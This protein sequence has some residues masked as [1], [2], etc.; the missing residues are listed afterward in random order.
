[1]A[2]GRGA[3]EQRRSCSP[4]PVLLCSLVTSY[5]LLLLTKGGMVLRFS[6]PMIHIARKNEAKVGEAV[7]VPD[8]L[9]VDLLFARQCDTVA[10][11]PPGDR[12]RQMQKRSGDGAPGKH[13]L[14]KGWQL[15]LACVDVS[16]EGLD[17]LDCH[18]W[19]SPGALVCSLRQGQVCAKNEQVILYPSHNPVH[20]FW[21]AMTAR[22]AQD[23][24]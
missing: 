11:S 18:R 16:L 14:V 3:E 13:K 4:A 1:M 12:A 5:A 22:Q 7:E 23:G 15:C 17:V 19:N 6:A 2:K 21:E 9:R 8:N 20:A 10:F 24:I